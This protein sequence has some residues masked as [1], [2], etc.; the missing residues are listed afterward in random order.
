MADDWFDSV[1]NGIRGLTNDAGE[2]FSS[3]GS[4]ASDAI[5]SQG[6]LPSLSGGKG[7]L[8]ALI[9]GAGATYDKQKTGYEK[10]VEVEKLNAAGMVPVKKGD[11]SATKTKGTASVDPNQITAEWMNRLDNF[12]SIKRKTGTA[13]NEY[14][15]G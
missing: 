14:S 13:I 12:V 3:M 5:P 2:L 6:S 15:A 10:L 4:A 9:K 7:I 11:Y 1:M 8:N